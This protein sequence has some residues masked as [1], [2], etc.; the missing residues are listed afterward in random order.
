MAGRDLAHS[1]LKA[2][3]ARERRAAICAFSQLLDLKDFGTGVH[4]TRLAEWGVRVGRELG[5]GSDRLHD[6]EIAAILHD[7]GKIGV[8]DAILKKAG[9]LTA[10]ER[11]EMQKHAEYGWQVLHRIPAFERASLYVLHHHETY[12]GRGYPAGLRGDETPI[13]ARIVAIIDAFDAMTSTRPYRDGLPVPEAIA[14]L[15]RAA[16]TQFD[17][18][19]TPTFIRIATTDAASVFEVAGREA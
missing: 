17:P 13:E 15:E 12:D 1:T 6:L 3:L 4:S 7:V 9:P 19:L 14:R 16:G 18:V 2:Q 11:A 5:L 8:P 10:E